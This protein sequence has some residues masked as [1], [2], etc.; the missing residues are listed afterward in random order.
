MS[1]RKD[2][3][4]GRW[5]AIVEIG[6]YGDRKR[7]TKRFKTKAEAV[8][9]EREITTLA[10]NTDIS[11]YDITLEALAK[12]WLEHKKKSGITNGTFS[13]YRNEVNAIKALPFYQT[14]AREIRLPD[15]E[16][17]LAALGERYT[18]AYLASI[19]TTLSSIMNYG[20]DKDWLI[21]NPC[22]RAR[23]PLRTK[24]GREIDSF[25]KEEVKAI[26]AHYKEFTFGDII[27][28]ML[29]TGIRT[30]EACCIDKSNISKKNGICY[31]HITNAM[32]KDFGGRWVKGS[33]KTANSERT[34][35]ISKEV[36]D[37]IAENCIANVKGLFITGKNHS[38][39]S[40][41]GFVVRYKKFFEMLNDS[42]SNPVTYRPPHCCRHTFASR[43]NWSGIDVKITQELMGHSDGAMTFHYTHIQEEDKVEAMKKI[44]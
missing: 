39:I 8:R 16:E 22:T 41:N 14:K 36:Y 9:W 2:K 21:K 32:N 31:L 10:Q 3:N 24:Q 26:E 34:I 7:K 17:A 6:T 38:Y 27:Y 42:I 33:T 11:G 30:Q 12:Q 28:V 35:P 4:T 18:F 23:M 5:I 37:I 15:I 20:I 25:T 29:N 13:K 19:K 40:Y 43:C 1:V 44:I